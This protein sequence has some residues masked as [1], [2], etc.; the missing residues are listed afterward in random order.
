MALQWHRVAASDQLTP[1]QPLACEAAGIQ[2]AIFRS[3]GQLYAVEDRCPH[4][5]HPLHRGNVSGG[6]LICSWHGWEFDLARDQPHLNPE[7]RCTAYPI[8]ED[9]AG[10]H[11]GIDPDNLPPSPGGFRRERLEF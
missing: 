6:R 10:V 8:R 5:A 7:A 4:M 3:E 9:D 1:D 11:V 2:L